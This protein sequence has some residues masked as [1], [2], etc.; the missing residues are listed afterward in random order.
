V[1]PKRT[2]SDSLG[3]AIA[4]RRAPTTSRRQCSYAL[5][6]STIEERKNHL[7]LFRRLAPHAGRVVP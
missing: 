6:V 4:D 2:L 7:L 5:I 1:P 3:A